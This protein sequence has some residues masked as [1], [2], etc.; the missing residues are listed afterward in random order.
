[1]VCRPNASAIPYDPISAFNADALL[2]CDINPSSEFRLCCRQ[3]GQNRILG[4]Y[5]WIA[6]Y[7]PRAHL[8]VEKFLVIP[9]FQII[10]SQQKT[11][12]RRKSKQVASVG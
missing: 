4:D 3:P 9:D 8:Y 11:V 12:A 10:S 7:M 1:V 5:F 6:A 2:R